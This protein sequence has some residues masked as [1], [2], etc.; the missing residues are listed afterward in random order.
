MMNLFEHLFCR[1]YWWNIY[2]VK[3]YKDITPFVSFCTVAVIQ[4]LNIFAIIDFYF[5]YHVQNIRSEPKW[6][7]P[8]VL[9]FLCIMNYFMYVHKSKYREIIKEFDKQRKDKIKKKEIAKKDIL[10]VVYI[11]ITV[12]LVAWSII[13][14]PNYRGNNI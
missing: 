3:N 4:E 11:L 1:V 6:F 8:P 5:M 9:V 10:L 7:H 12:G 14:S 13:D 2:V